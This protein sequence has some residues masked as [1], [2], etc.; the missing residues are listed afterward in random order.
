[1]AGVHIALLP[2]SRE[3][4]GQSIV[5]LFSGAGGMSAGF[6]DMGYGIQ[7]AA[8][9][10][11]GKPGTVIPCNETYRLNFGVE[12]LDWD[13][14][15][16]SPEDLAETLGLQPGQLQIL[17]SCPPCTGFSQKR[18]KQRLGQ[19]ADRERQAVLQLNSLFLRT[20]DFV[21]V[22]APE[23]LVME[24]VPSVLSH[25]VYSV[26]R[27][28]L[29]DMGYRLSASVIDFADYGLPQ[30]RKRAI[31]IG[32]HGGLPVPHLARPSICSR[33]TVLE[34]LGRCNLS[35]IGNGEADPND[36][37]HACPNVGAHQNRVLNR[38][39]LIRD[40]GSG[41]WR[42]LHLAELS[43][44]EVGLLTPRIRTAIQEGDLSTYP[45]CYGTMRPNNVSQTI[46]RQCGDI[47]TGAWFHWSQDRMLS[48]REMSVLQGFPYGVPN[49]GAAPFYRFAGSLS[50]IYQQVGNA[51]P[52]LISRML[53]KA[54]LDESHC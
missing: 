3:P 9:R 5:D 12:P 41:R 10:Q 4:N 28:S 48:A 25:P 7:G 31:I 50:Q 6:W 40:K 23:F 34:A 53:A 43:P 51:V 17:I 19:H 29:E 21:R 42:N 32:R 38:C 47:G 35:Q 14:G 52:P 46:V 20:A 45:D 54:I 8:D 37:V 16:C 1:M 11:V 39:K 13:L 26:L 2:R 22:L 36:P 27:S 15:T 30:S 44:S 18:P 49:D 24:N 33:T